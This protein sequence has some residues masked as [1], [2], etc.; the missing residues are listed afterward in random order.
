M[1]NSNLVDCV[2]GRS[3]GFVPLRTGVTPNVTIHLQI[4]GPIAHQPR[5]L[6]LARERYRSG[7]LMARRERRKLDAAADGLHRRQV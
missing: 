5:W 6:Q 4:I 1:T 2:T 3:A 7:Y